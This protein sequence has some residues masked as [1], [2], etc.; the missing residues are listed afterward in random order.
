MEE[1]ENKLEKDLSIN[2]IKLLIITHL[3]KKKMKIL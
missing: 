2:Q 1:V 3:H